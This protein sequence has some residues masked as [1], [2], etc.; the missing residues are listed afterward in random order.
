[1]LL[2]LTAAT[3]RARG[4]RL[5]THVAESGEE[6][7][8]FQHAR[9]PMFEWLGRNERDLTDCGGLSPVAA[10]ERQGLLG[11]DFTSGIEAGS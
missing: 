9:G 5:T 10:L 1:L 8:M 6:F 7:D 4:W 2:S 3:A 11:P